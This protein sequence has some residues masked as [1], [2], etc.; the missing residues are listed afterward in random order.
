MRQSLPLPPADL[1]EGHT[2]LVPGR[3]EFF[4]RD[5]GGDGPAVMLLHGWMVSADINWYAAYAP[6]QEAGYRVLA[7]DH[8]GHGRGLRT[9]AHFRLGDCADDAAAVIEQLDPGPVIAVGYSMG[10][11]ITSL[12]ARNHQAL[13]SGIVL[14]ATASDWKATRRDKLLWSSMAGLRFALGAF[15]GGSWRAG[16]RMA[17]FPKTPRATWFAAEL[18]RG[19][20]RDLAEAGRELGRFDSRSWIGSVDVPAAVIVTARDRGVPPYKQREL[21]KLLGAATYELQADHAAV[22]AVAHDFNPLLLEAL[23]TL[24]EPEA[25]AAT[26]V[27]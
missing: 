8:R 20:A 10:G 14:C 21:A 1:L 16:M 6:L 26:A 27:Y 23:R 12:L 25:V 22:S 4:V 24:R 5:S 7:M 19:S 11:P 17:G 9:P 13:L 3:G 15:P 18:T 2:V